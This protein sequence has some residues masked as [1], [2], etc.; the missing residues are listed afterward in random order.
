M[1]GRAEELLC[2][3]SAR[4]IGVAIHHHDVVAVS[5]HR[6]IED[7]LHDLAP[8]FMFGRRLENPS[9]N[10]LYSPGVSCLDTVTRPTLLPENRSNSSPLKE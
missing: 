8:S 2:H 7:R 3:R 9:R 5:Q 10:Q 6:A 1:I 4:E